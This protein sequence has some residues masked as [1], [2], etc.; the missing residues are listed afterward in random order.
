MIEFQ[1]TT[2][3]NDEA[4]ALIKSGQAQDGLVVLAH[5]QTRGRGRRGREWVSPPGNL[6][7]SLILDVS[8]R[9]A[10]A[11]QLG[12]VAAVALVDALRMLLPTPTFSCKWPNDVLA[13]TRK[14]A[15][16]LLEA[17][18]PQWLVLGLGVDVAQSPPADMIERP[19]TSLNELGYAGD[20]RAVLDG[21]YQ[22]MM[23]LV[24]QWR[25]SG[26][27]GIRDAWKDRAYGIGGPI[28]VRL[29]QETFDGLFVDLDSDGAMLVTD[30]KG[31]D[32][33]V[34]AG[35]VFMGGMSASSH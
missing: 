18:G 31:N 28:K 13:N 22:Q 1:S 30:N 27:A 25:Q 33:K 10:Q 6:H 9:R 12:F 29:D 3:T 2:S 4:R 17:D 23:P 20:V 8:L 7:C 26:F 15:G 34:L 24:G 11:A 19:A 14:V 5:Q 21:F 32:R 35:D 16:M